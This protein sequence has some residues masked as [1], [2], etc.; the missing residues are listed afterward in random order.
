MRARSVGDPSLKTAH[1]KVIARRKTHARHG[2]DPLA[3]GEGKIIMPQTPARQRAGRRRANR[4]TTITH[5]PYM[6]QVNVRYSGTSQAPGHHPGAQSVRAAAGGTG[7]TTPREQGG[8]GGCWAENTQSCLV[9][10]AGAP[11]CADE[12]QGAQQPGLGWRCQALGARGHPAASPPWPR[13]REH[14]GASHG[15]GWWRGGG[16]VEGRAWGRAALCR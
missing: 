12:E 4:A 11:N 16:L 15:V 9:P 1:A 10:L 6:A 5:P 2:R 3:M 14:S 7:A 8:C 13:A